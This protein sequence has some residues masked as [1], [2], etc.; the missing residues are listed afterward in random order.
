M[1]ISLPRKRPFEPAPP[2]GLRFENFRQICE[3][4]FGDGHNSFAHSMAWFKN[5]L[6][7]GTTRSNFCMIQV[8]KYFRD[9]NLAVWPIVEGPK[10]VD[11][12]DTLDRRA[13]IWRYDPLEDSW[14]QVLRAPMVMGSDGKEVARE[15]GYRAMAVVQ[16]ESDVEP[17]LYVA[18]WAPR[19]GPGPLILRSEDGENFSV[20]SE[21]GILGLPITTTRLLVPFKGRLFTSPTGTRGKVVGQFHVSGGQV[22]VS[23]IPIL[24][25]SRDPANGQWREVSLPGFGE[26]ENEGIFM[27]CPFGEQLYAG[28]FNCQGFQIWRSD[29]E[30][31]PPYKWIKVIDQG[32]YRG[33]LNQIA[34][35]M[36]VFNDALYIGT[37]IQNGGHDHQN[38]IGPAAPELIRIFPDDSWDL[39]VG[40]R[41]DTPD[42]TKRPLSGL[43]PGFGNLFNG[44][45]WC[46][47]VHDG[48]LYLGTNNICVILSWFLRDHYP[49]RSRRLLERVGVDNVVK[50]QGGFALWRT[51]DGENWLNVNRHGFGT[52]YNIGARNLVS[53]PYGLFLG[54]ANP[55]GPRVAVKQDGEWIYSDNPRGG[56]EVWLGT[57][58][59]VNHSVKAE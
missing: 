35:S 21:Y 6:Y 38:N 42:G 26:P 53:T 32:A 17:V 20:V 19:R 45:F 48:W 43:P 36:A 37:G 14:Q 15:L 7:V 8:Q 24:Y 10:D 30:G 11:S 5:H 47:E 33:S 31:E 18:T 3:N 59:D 28:T 25:E 51:R 1:T 29:C 56:L 13:Q 50:H 49:N 27:L 55:F 52:P 2:P 41:R 9:L 23:G 16:G 34:M 4:G 12:L 40:T 58:S 46:M 57:K 44:Y 54:T 22:N 39:I